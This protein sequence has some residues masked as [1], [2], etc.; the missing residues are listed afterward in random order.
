MNN[1]IIH[2]KQVYEYVVVIQPNE[3]LQGR[4]SQVRREFNVLY[5][6][7]HPLLSNVHVP[8][9][10]FTQNIG[11]QDK[12]IR[13]FRL[14][15]MRSHPF[16]IRL[17]N[18]DSFPTYTIFIS[19]TEK[20]QFQEFVKTLRTDSQELL[21]MDELHKPN[22]ILEPYI[23]IAIKLLPWQYERGW[24]QYSNVNF[25]ASFI[26]DSIVLLKRRQGEIKYF[27]VQSFNLM[28][29]E[30]VTKQASIFDT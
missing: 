1:P 4:I 7:E 5:R 28:N 24:L 12:I 20:N 2:D 19:G 3:D 8:L 26:A 21:K 16:K 13:R 27:P 10:Y 29:L 14:L 25:N 9:V 15:A 17:N 11:F 23:P 22:F 18:F 30:P 6:V